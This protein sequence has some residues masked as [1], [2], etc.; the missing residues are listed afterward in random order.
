MTF[1]QL[2]EYD[3]QIHGESRDKL[4]RN[5]LLEAD[6]VPL[7]VAI[8]KTS[9]PRGKTSAENE[10]GQQQQGHLDEANSCCPDRSI[11]A[12]SDFQETLSAGIKDSLAITQTCPTDNEQLLLGYGCI[13]HDNTGGAMIGPLYARS[14]GVC[15]VILR[16]L[17]EE[18]T[19]EPGGKYSVMSLTSNE[20]AD[21][22]LRL[23]GLRKMDQCSRMFTKFIPEAPLEQIYYVHSP[24]F[25]LF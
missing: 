20:Q 1:Q 13:R 21:E 25:T 23:I 18:F 22:L 9:L 24:N 5:Y 14:S 3:A 10:A 15:E 4:L 12:G 16:H 19:M 8:I 17:I 6:E 7:T 11:A 2:I